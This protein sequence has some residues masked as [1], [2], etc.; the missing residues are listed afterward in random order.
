MDL[1]TGSG[2]TL[3]RVSTSLSFVGGLATSSLASIT[4]SGLSSISHRRHVWLVVAAVLA[5][6]ATL[7]LLIGAIANSSRNRIIVTLTLVCA[8]FLP[9]A[10]I[11]LALF[12]WIRHALQASEIAIIFV[13]VPSSL[14]LIA[15]DAA[16]TALSAMKLL[17]LNSIEVTQ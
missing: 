15:V 12:I 2:R 7:G 4:A 9:I 3:Y 13:A 5:N 14:L 1:L 11:G 8:A 17:Q 16:T 6:L 10:V